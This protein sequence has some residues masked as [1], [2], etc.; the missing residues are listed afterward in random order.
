MSD[1]QWCMILGSVLVVCLSILVVWAVWFF[2]QWHKLDRILEQFQ[3]GTYGKTDVQRGMAGKIDTLD[4]QETRESRLVSEMRQVLGRAVW[5]EEQAKK[6]K[7]QVMELISDLSHQLKTPLANI[8]MDMELLESNELSKERQAEFLGHAKAQATRMQ[9]LMQDLLKAS[10]LENGIIH[11]EAEDIEVKPTIAKAVGA[12]YAQAAKKQIEL[13]VEEFED[14][15]LYHNPKWTAEA[16][17]NV[18][19]NAVKYSPVGSRIEI[20]IE[21]MELYSCISVKDHGMGIPEQEYNKIFQR[22]YRG[23]QAGAEEGTGLGLY[24]AQLILQSEQ[25]YITVASKS[26]EGSCFRFFLQNCH[27]FSQGLS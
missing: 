27:N 21:R 1:R 11:F 25:G 3:R 4:V 12:V 20:G 15:K 10:R 14:F 23:R 9:W 24:L 17:V 5:Q 22:F 26:G 8:V 13:I 6:E 2:R 16:L 19:E 7:N 18:L